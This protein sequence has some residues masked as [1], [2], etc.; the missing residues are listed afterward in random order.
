M[1]NHVYT[2]NYKQM[3]LTMGE[4]CPYPE[5][6]EKARSTAAS[7]TVPA[8]PVDDR[9]DCIFH[10]REVAW[11]RDNDFEGH[12]LQLVGL[13]VADTAAK[14]YDFAEFVFVGGG[15]TGSSG[16]HKVHI[17]DTVFL[18]QA[19]FTAASF[20]D[21][22]TLEAINFRDGASFCQATFAGDLKVTNARFGGLDLTGAEF[23]R[24][25][26]FTK[27][28]LV[29]FALF[30]KARFTGTAAGHVV[31]FEDS[32]FD[33]ITDFSGATFVLGDE[34][35]VEF[36]RTRFEES[37]DFKGTR[38][39]C[40][41]IFSD[42]SFAGVT[43]FIDTSFGTV[44]SSA[45]YRGSPVEFNRIEVTA[46][47]VLRFESTDPQQKLFNH[48]VQLSFKEA[49]A[50]LICFQNVNF[51]NISAASRERLTH[52][53][54]LGKVE[55]GSGCI[56]YRFQTPIKKISVS[57][58]NT[59]LILEICQTFTNYFTARNGL[60]LGLE[61]VERNS[62]EVHFFY[63]TDE[64]I[65]E[66]IFRERLAVTE[67]HL[68]SLLSVRSD[69]QLPALD[70]SATLARSAG[71]ESAVI[72]AVD[73]VTAMFSI[74]FRAGIRIALQKWKEVDTRALLGAIR[75]NDDDPETRAQGLH[76]VLVH[77]YT[78]ATLFGI[79]IQQ[80]AGLPPMILG[81]REEPTTEAIDVAI[82]TAIKVERMAVCEAFGLGKAHRIKR[83]GRW[84]WR[85]QLL[86]DGGSAY[87]VVVAQPADMGQVEATALTK[88]VLRD[89]KPSAALLVGI[90]ASTDPEK[91]KLG[92]V[93]VGKS[94]WYYEHGKVTPNGTKPQP[95]MMQADAGFLQHFTGM[96]GWNGKVGV[97]RPDDSESKPKVHQGVIASG[98]KVIADAAA[99]DEIAS[100]HRKIIA[101]AME[102]YGFSRA[103]WQST[104][105]VQHLVVRGICDDGSVAKD[106]RWHG[107]AA[108]AAAAFAKH[109][110][111]DGPLSPKARAVRPHP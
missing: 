30:G 2:A 92:D 20:L 10:S 103:I 97:E 28:E 29:S 69:D 51:S 72:N 50:G 67:Q 26:F 36:R 104:E 41:V 89:W 13:L 106:D 53:A 5:F 39:H 62:T 8:L 93:V 95:E 70:T 101:I 34:S 33:A 100:G 1:C 48:D 23:R 82:L 55:I 45:R 3:P 79:N 59:P 94:V 76:R 16:P 81:C 68:W 109:F 7:G 47:A 96:N 21:S 25:V 11:K 98:E 66:A 24:L 44:G 14:Y 88:D 38:F 22:L 86:L 77:R 56:K 61:V 85:G 6:Y 75:F 110:L 71:K 52:F 83:G 35:T 49:P 42:V 9:G 31:K 78:G 4:R 90:A 73:G 40:Q 111:L 108:G 60:N 17:A 91:V 65:S 87:E 32:R 18:Q 80:H 57:D 74:F 58:G 37:A 27:V 99:R 15:A 102:E 84:Y 54:R 107:Y 43:E 19:Y 46:S 105:R 63:F 12:F 64:D